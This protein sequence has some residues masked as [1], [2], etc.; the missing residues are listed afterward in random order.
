MEITKMFSSMDGEKLFTICFSE[1]EMKLYSKF[2]G[3]RKMWENRILDEL[4]EGYANQEKAGN[5]FKNLS[6]DQTNDF[7]NKKTS[8]KNLGISDLQTKNSMIAERS[9][10]ND[11]ADIKRNT[12]RKGLGIDELAEKK[13]NGM[14]NKTLTSEE[15]QRLDKYRAKRAAKV[16]APKPAAVATSAQK[17]VKSNLPAV[18]TK[19]TAVLPK[20]TLST[21]AKKASNQY[22]KKGMNFVKKHKVGVGIGAAGLTAAGVTGA[23]LYNKKKNQ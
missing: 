1:D 22:L 3:S 14:M 15:K 8:A 17:T 5:V 12:Y 19:T 13:S 11:R 16:Q 18:A 21:G 7:L 6:K 20:E 4:P 23:Y 2:K 9:L 10:R